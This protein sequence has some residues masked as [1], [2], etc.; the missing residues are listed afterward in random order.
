VPL[1][2][3]FGSV[4]TKSDAPA[5]VAGPSSFFSTLKPAVSKIYAPTPV[6]TLPSSSGKVRTP[7]AVELDL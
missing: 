2:S 3:G 1:F 5:P 4:T 7:L 6:A